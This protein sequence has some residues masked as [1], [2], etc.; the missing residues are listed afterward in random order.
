MPPRRR[1]GTGYRGV[2]VLLCGTYCT[3]IRSGGGMRLRLGTFDTAQ[4][5]AH[6]Y[7]AAAWRFLRSRQDT[8][9]AD[10]ATR[11]RTQELASFPRLLTEEDHRKHRRR[12]HRL[13]LAEM[14]KQAMALWSHC[15]PHDIIN[16]EQFFA[17]RRAEKAK[18]REERAAYREDKRT[19]KAIAKYNQA[20]GDAS[21]WNSGDE[22]FLDAYAPTSEEDITE[23]ESELDE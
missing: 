4:E 5:G 6:A 9:F 14:D 15:F 21:S 17:E 19:R 7:D 18:R 16:E 23:T 20:L 1:G 22:R 3:E 8:N 10:V 12:Q 11:E 2:R 13:R